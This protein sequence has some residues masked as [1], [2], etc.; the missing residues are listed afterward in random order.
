MNDLLTKLSSYNVFNY[1]LPGVVFAILAS[2][3]VHYPVVQH[4]ILVGAFLYYFIG[5]AVSRFGSLIIE[6]LLK[7]SS[8]VRF[9]DYADFVAASKKDTQLEVLSE[10]N[11]TYRTLCSLFGL[12]LL[13]KVYLRMESRFPYLRD[14]N[15]TS[16]AAVL[17]ILFLFSYRKQTAYIAKRVRI[18]CIDRA[19]P[20][21]GAAAPLADAKVGD[22]KKAGA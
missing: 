12:L 20:A 3:I 13:L 8:F 16:L 2:A 15:A 7:W 19:A 11:N 22:F 21:P 6:P 4:D 5:L 10:A 17:L 14:W 1:L 18:A 9:A